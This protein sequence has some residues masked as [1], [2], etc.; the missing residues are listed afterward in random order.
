MRFLV[1]SGEP[2]NEIGEILRARERERREMGIEEEIERYIYR[3]REKETEG[4]RENE[5]RNGPKLCLY[6]NF[7]H[8]SQIIEIP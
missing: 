1:D 7:I 4:M 2:N 6:M 5:R 3:H 8:Y